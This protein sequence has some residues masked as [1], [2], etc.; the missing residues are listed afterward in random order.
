MV[1]KAAFNVKAIGAERAAALALF[2]AATAARAAVHLPACCANRWRPSINC[3]IICVVQADRAKKLRLLVAAAASFGACSPRSSSPA[4]TASSLCFQFGSPW[5]RRRRHK[6]LL[7]LL[8]LIFVLLLPIF[9][10]TLLVAVPAMPAF[11]ALLPRPW[12]PAERTLFRVGVYQRRL[13]LLLLALIFVLL[14]PIVLLALLVAVPALP[15]P[16]A[17]LPRPWLLAKRT[18]F[19][20]LIYLR[21][22]MVMWRSSSIG[23]SSSSRGVATP[24]DSAHRCHTLLV[25]VGVNSRESWSGRSAKFQKFQK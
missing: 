4:A 1:C 16:V 6:H 25:G 5:R 9:L 8:A 12:L 2:G 3:R 23:S 17:L 22:I 24:T 21:R 11:G 19:N 7:Q 18:L 14:P 20:V 15:A 10:L 13:Q